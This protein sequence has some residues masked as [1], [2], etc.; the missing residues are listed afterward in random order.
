VTLVG[1]TH[2]LFSRPGQGFQPK[3]IYAPAFSQYEKRYVVMSQNASVG[4]TMGPLKDLSGNNWPDLAGQNA[5]TVRLDGPRYYAELDGVDDYI[6][7][8]GSPTQTART[9]Y[10]VQRVRELPASPR[11]LWIISSSQLVLYVNSADNQLYVRNLMS[12]TNH[13]TGLLITL[14]RWHVFSLLNNGNTV[15]VSLDGA[16]RQ[17]T[18]TGL[19]GNTGATNVGATSAAP[20]NG[21]VDFLEWI[22]WAQAHGYASRQS[23]V[24]SMKLAWSL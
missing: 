11:F 19:N 7:S 3:F 21:A 8:A 20:N 16:E 2:N 13:A 12:G 15:L 1:T 6:N 17:L 23:V 18:L 10:T 14:G 24:S 4:S 22:M 9:I 5:P